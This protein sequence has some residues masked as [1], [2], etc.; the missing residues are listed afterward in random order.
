MNPV[1]MALFIEVNRND[2][3]RQYRAANASASRARRRFGRG[4]QR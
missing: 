1:M 3:E 2:R 4:E